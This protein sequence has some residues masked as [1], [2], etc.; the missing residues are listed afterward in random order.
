MTSASTA[1]SFQPLRVNRII[2]P[3]LELG[4]H[5]G[6]RIAIDRLVAGDDETESG[7]FLL[8]V[9]ALLSGHL[10]SEVRKSRTISSGVRW[11]MAA[12]VLTATVASS[13][14]ETARR[15]HRDRARVC[16]TARPAG[17]DGAPPRETS[18]DSRGSRRPDWLGGL[19]AGSRASQPRW[20]V[21]LTP[22]EWRMRR[23][24]VIVLE[25][26]GDGQA[27][28]SPSGRA[29]RVGRRKPGARDV[30]EAIHERTSA[31]VADEGNPL[32]GLRSLGVERGWSR[33]N[34]PR[35]NSAG[36]PGHKGRSR[37]CQRDEACRF[38]AVID[39]RGPEAGIVAIR[40]RFPGIAHRETARPAALLGGLQKE[41]KYPN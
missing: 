20:E 24:E 30:A 9:L 41:G 10:G 5:I 40:G 15:V 23:M 16:S 2:R 39:R 3:E 28:T 14:R 18:V 7:Q 35:R 13:T 34:R 31:T 38:G 11:V 29:I 36:S 25:T 21:R 33:A 8:H 6:Q 12:G 1:K 32:H 17:R 22:Q 27:G 26:V 19:S 4:L 37:H